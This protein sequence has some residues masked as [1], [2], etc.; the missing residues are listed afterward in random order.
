MIAFF[1]HHKCASSA[2]VAYLADLSERSALGF[3][4]S[5]LG[6][7][8][9]T[10]AGYDLCCLTN[11]QYAAVRGQGSGPALHLIRNPLSVVLSAYH[12]HRTSHSVD[13]WPLL[14]AQRA[15]L[16]AADRTTGMLL[17]AQFCNSEEFYPDTPGPLHAMRHWNYDDP[18]IRTLRIEDGLDRLT[19]FLRAALGPAGDALVWPDQADF[20]FERLAGRR[21]GETDDAAHYRAGDAEAWKTELPREVIDYVVGACREV[22]ER[23]YPESLDWAGRV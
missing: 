20:A 5:H 11:A 16:L 9:P 14:A 23:F 6:S 2:L 10:A 17:T 22:L 13:G 8:R 19:D 4:T 18:A 15:R 7:A 1:T 12:S 21:A 3:F